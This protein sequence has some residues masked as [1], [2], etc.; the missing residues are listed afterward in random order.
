VW[1]CSVSLLDEGRAG[2]NIGALLSGD[3]EEDV[4][5]GPGVGQEAG[6][7]YAAHEFHCAGVHLDQGGGRPAYAVLHE[8]ITRSSISGLR[9]VTGTVA[10]PEGTEMV[11][12]GDNT[13]M[14]VELGK[15]IAMDEGLR[16]RSVR[17]AV[18]LVSGRAS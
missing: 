10:L 2:D 9:N 8:L 18:L 12:P 15:P 7:D 13:E 6:F 16:S 11:M 5:R 1:R 17:G 4:E 3:E 14:T